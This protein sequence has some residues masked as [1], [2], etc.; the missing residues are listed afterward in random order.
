MGHPA[1]FATRAG[2]SESASPTA[3][4]NFANRLAR[5]SDLEAAG[6][7]PES[8]PASLA[9][10]AHRAGAEPALDVA[11]EPKRDITTAAPNTPSPWPGSPVGRHRHEE[12][13]LTLHSEARH[14]CKSSGLRPRAVVLEVHGLRKPRP[15]RSGL[16]PQAA[17]VTGASTERLGLSFRLRSGR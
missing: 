8:E 13:P 11:Q 12:R 7:E 4:S 5:R 6:L 3:S 1:H 9:D 2:L 15:S 17:R 14:T 10:G 16:S